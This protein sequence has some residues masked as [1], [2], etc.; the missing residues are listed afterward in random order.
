M[1]F[2]SVSGASTSDAVIIAVAVVFAVACFI[3]LIVLL[4]RFAG[5]DGEVYGVVWKLA[6]IL[7]A[8]FALRLIFAL[9]IR[10]YRNEYGIFVNMFDR[11]K[12]VGMSGYYKGNASGVLYP[13]T[14]FIYLIFGGLSNAMGL[15]NHDVGM[16]F[17]IKLPMII[18][19][20]LTALAIY[21]IAGKYINKATA[22]ILAAFIC[23]CP[24]FFIGS[25]IWCTQITFTVMFMCFACYFLARKKHALTIA[26][27]TLA[28]FS[29][30]EGIYIF[31]VVCVFSVYHLVRAAINV[32]RNKPHGGAV[33]ESDYRAVITVPVGFIASVIAVYLIGLFMM[34]SYSY[35]PFVYI[36]E[37]LLEPLTGWAYFTVDGLSVYSVFNRSGATPG[38]RFPSWLFLCLFAAIIFAVVFVVYFTKKNRATMVLLM[39]FSLFTMQVYYP[40][41]T[42]IGMQST[43]AVLVAAYA[44]NRDKRILTALF[45]VG[46]CFAINSLTVVANMGQLNNLSDYDLSSLTLPT[47]GIKAVTITCSV[48][49]VLAHLYFTLIAVSIGM[50]GQRKMLS[51]ARGLGGSIKE[52]F[53]VKKEK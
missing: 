5:H 3:A 31:P 22:L 45:I 21:K 24:I 50:T 42:A 34:H 49:T 40:G 38:A 25:S 33:L 39:A 19:D 18:A 27:A 16:Q 48:I 17:M 7:F 47:A 10:G 2:L 35:N 9:C 23:V 11:L 14:Y 1:K 53:A 46:L 41:T 44:L 29:S 8:G 36:Y 37:F 6:V 43:L 32:K 52:Y 26:F 20:L 12:L 13:V 51:P 4:C 28:A 30:K 15:S